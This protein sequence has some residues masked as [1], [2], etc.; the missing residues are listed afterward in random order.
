MLLFNKYNLG[1]TELKNRV[2]MAPMTRSRAIGNVPNEL[3]AKY[4]EQRS[5]AGLIITEGVSPSPNGLGYARIPGIFNKKQIDGWK[6]ITEAVHKKGGRIFIQLM[7]TGRVSHPDNLPEKTEVLGP[8]AIGLT[9]KMFTDQN[10]LQP[11]PIPKEM[12]QDDIKNTQQEYVQAAINAVEA[13]FDGVELHGANGYLICQFLNP[14]SNQRSD[15]YGGSAEK[16]NRFAL[17]TAKKVIEA[18]G[19]E[20]TAMRISPYGVSNEMDIFEGIEDQYE[21]LVS[22]LNK[23]NLSYVHIVDHSSMGAPEVPDSIKDKIRNAF[24]NTLILSGGYDKEKAEADLQDGKGDLVAFGRPFISNPDL[25]Y[26]ME[27]N[28]SLTPFITDTFYTPDEKGYT[29]YAFV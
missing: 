2:V 3:M 27:N 24:N 29:D 1:N 13:G 26:W 20:K 23:L 10:G 21:Q 7:H 6:K 11:F 8:S 16:R 18:I 19:A 25:V 12:T 15:Q 14:A 22:E 9:G 4:Y 17:E 28:L 5:G